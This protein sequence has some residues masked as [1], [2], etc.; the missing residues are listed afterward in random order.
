MV[1]AFRIDFCF[2]E[3]SLLFIVFFFLHTFLDLL[4]F[5]EWF[6][7]FLA[8]IPRPA[9][10]LARFQLVSTGR[11]RLLR[12]IRGAPGDSA[13]AEIDQLRTSLSTHVTELPLQ[14]VKYGP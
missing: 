6:T 12:S 14:A 1:D 2:S 5:S 3:S 11:R 9:V 13:A 7:G 10:Q 4:H 8:G